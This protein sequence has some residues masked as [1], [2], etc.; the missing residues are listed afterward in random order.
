MNYIEDARKILVETLDLALKDAGTDWDPDDDPG[1][2]DLYVLLLLTHGAHTT[3]EHV[4]DAWAIAADHVDS[5]HRWLVPI[6]QLAPGVVAQDAP[7][8]Q[9]IRRAAIRLAALRRSQA[10]ASAPS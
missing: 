1:L 7:Y 8:R 4:H 2:F 10:R 6:S 9:A 3:V 5:G